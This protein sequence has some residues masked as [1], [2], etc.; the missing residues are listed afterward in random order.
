MDPLRTIDYIDAFQ[1][2]VNTLVLCSGYDNPY[3]KKTEKVEKKL[4]KFIH[5]VDEDIFNIECLINDIRETIRTI[6]Y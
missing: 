4:N 3:N 2:A 6:K 5:E 1:E